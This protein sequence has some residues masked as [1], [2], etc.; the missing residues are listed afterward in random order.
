MPVVT[1]PEQNPAWIS[2][3]QPVYPAV[4]RA[5]K[6]VLTTLANQGKELTGKELLDLTDL[7]RRTIY[8]AS[9]ELFRK[10]LLVFKPSLKDTRQKFF[11]LT[12]QGRQAAGV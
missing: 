2:P 3:A 7:P 9:K 12:E 10:G 8:Q 11:I 4:S 1:D 5:Q 6:I